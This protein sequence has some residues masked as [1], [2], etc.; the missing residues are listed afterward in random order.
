MKISNLK[1]KNF[2]CSW[3][4]R[5]VSSLALY[6]A[7]KNGGIP[8]KLL[9]IFT[10]I[11]FCCLH[12][13]VF[14]DSND[15]AVEV[16]EYVPGNNLPA[17]Y[18]NT[19][20]VLGKAATKTIWDDGEE[21][22]D[23]KVFLPAFYKTDIISLGN[24]GSLTLKMGKKVYDEDDPIHPFGSDLIVYGNTLFS[25]LEVAK[26]YASPWKNISAEKAKIWL[27][28]DLTNWFCV[29]SKNIFADSLFPTQSIDLEGNPSDYLYPVNPALLTND[30]T[31]QGDDV[32]DENLWSYTNTVEAY[33]GSAGGTP[34]DLS[35]L[36]DEHGNPTNL[37]W[38]L[39]VKFV[40]IDDG[41]NTIAEIDA[42]AAVRSLPEPFSVIDFQ[43]SIFGLIFVILKMDFLSD[44][45]I[46]FTKQ[47]IKKLTG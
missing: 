29:R 35:Y 23:I 6:F 33:D 5:K 40:D 25:V 45:K 19:A 36:E 14:A 3:I 43:F 46:E 41:F 27:S 7:I 22:T 39:F 24:K 26:P 4:G 9:C 10:I 1:I 32:D 47:S 17:G 2:F 11:I 16:I 44:R 31:N 13:T 37:Q 15:W 8:K 34:I 42:V 38:I 20:A 12:S 28:Q 21:D 18:T 30:W